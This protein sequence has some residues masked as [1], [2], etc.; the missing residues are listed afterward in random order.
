[1]EAAQR[2]SR[3]SEYPL[4]EMS[5]TSFT[6]YPMHLIAAKGT[7]DFS[8]RYIGDFSVRLQAAGFSIFMRNI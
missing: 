1:M 5:I 7:R 8:R 6:A 4:H 3:L 2:V